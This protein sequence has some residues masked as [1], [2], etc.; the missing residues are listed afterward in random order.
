MLQKREEALLHMHFTQ[1]QTLLENSNILFLFFF[2]FVLWLV[3]EIMVQS[4]L[5][6]ESLIFNL[7]N[8]FSET[9]SRECIYKYAPRSYA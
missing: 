5:Y 9:L 7:S 4:Y 2:R 3:E 6:V 8:T 1:K